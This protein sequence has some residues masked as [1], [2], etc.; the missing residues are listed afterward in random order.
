MKI[1]IFIN[2][3]FVEE[4]QTNGPKKYKLD[5]HLYWESSLKNWAVYLEYCW[6]IYISSIQI[7]RRKGNFELWSSFVTN[8]VFSSQRIMWDSQILIKQFLITKLLYKYIQ[9]NHQSC[10][11]SFFMQFIL[12][13][14][15]SVIFFS[16]F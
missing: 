5:A 14:F 11:N 1:F 6:E 7:H 16:P 13:F 15:V 3:Y 4:Q 9:V 2:K 12:S 10:C 8:K